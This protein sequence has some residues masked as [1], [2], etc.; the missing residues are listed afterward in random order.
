MAFGSRS[1]AGVNTGVRAA[2]SKI[3]APAGVSGDKRIGG[4]KKP[5]RQG[6]VGGISTPFSNRMFK[7]KSY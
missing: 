7:G 6:K 5:G 2:S 4:L 3:N 1:V